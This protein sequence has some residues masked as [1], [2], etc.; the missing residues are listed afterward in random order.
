MSGTYGSKSV[1][2]SVDATALKAAPRVFHRYSY[3]NGS[4]MSV[5]NSPAISWCEW[6]P[7]QC[8]SRVVI[9]LS[10]NSWSERGE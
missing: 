10:H 7:Y 3:S 9:I 5:L 4:R 1:L 8:V 6:D 2:H